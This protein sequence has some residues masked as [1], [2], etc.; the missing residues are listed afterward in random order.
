MAAQKGK[1]LLIKL[2][3]GGGPEL[4]DPEAVPLILRELRDRGYVF[5][6]VPELYGT[7]PM[8]PGRTYESAVDSAVS[9]YGRPLP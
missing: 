5:V 3:D 7:L 6:T 9:R 1:D 4:G 2:G 8:Q